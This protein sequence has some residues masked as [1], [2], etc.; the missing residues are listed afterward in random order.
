MAL[1]HIAANATVLVLLGDVPLVRADLLAECSRAA[2][3]PG[4]PW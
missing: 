1:P 4:S 3:A 2:P